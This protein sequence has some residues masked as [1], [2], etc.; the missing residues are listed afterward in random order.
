MAPQDD[1]PHTGIDWQPA[2]KLV[3]GGTL[4]SEFQETSEGVFLNSGYVYD[5]AE[6]A[7]ARFKGED[8]GYIYSRY[9]NPTVNMFEARMTALAVQHIRRLANAEK[10]VIKGRRGLEPALSY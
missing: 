9:S 6:Q 2:T 7:E 3:H 4:R 5:S 8:A 10:I 1:R